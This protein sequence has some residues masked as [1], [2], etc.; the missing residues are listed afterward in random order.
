MTLFV[1]SGQDY[2]CGHCG[3]VIPT[4]VSLL[5]DENV[6]V[7][8]Y[9]HDKNIVHEC[10]DTSG[11]ELPPPPPTAEEHALADQEVQA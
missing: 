7:L 11:L 8:G 5:G 9:D 3:E 1:A 2:L 4:A 10:G 6:G